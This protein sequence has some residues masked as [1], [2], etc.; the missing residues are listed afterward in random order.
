MQGS[1]LM[2]KVVVTGA[3]SFIGRHLVK[4]LSR[5][6]DL[7]LRL[8]VHSKPGEESDGICCY[9]GDLLF[10]ETLTEFFAGASVAINLAYL[11]SRSHDDNLAAACN[12]AD[13]CAQAGVTRVI[14]CSTAVVSGRTKTDV[15]T[16]ATPCLPANDYE[17]TKLEMEKVLLEKAKGRFELVIIRPTA[18]FGP[19]GKNLLKMAQELRFGNGAVNYFRSCLFGLRRLNLVSINTIVGAVEFLMD[20][21]AGVDGEV[22]IVSD[23]ESYNNNYGYV[24][25]RMRDFF[26]LKP[27]ILPVV[28]LPNSMLTAALQLAGRSNVNPTR[29]Y[30]CDKLLDLG[31]RKNS[32]FESCL[33]LYLEWYA[34]AAAGED[35]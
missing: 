33:D 31:Y 32:T 22:F 5:R 2:T 34:N 8:L 35:L 15:V 24:E 19:N 26:R 1:K 18:V 27:Y 12:M 6:R 14:H 16:E 29:T 28:P 11:W 17:L 9:R 13:A 21:V 4:E 23:D 3:H 20:A 10:P 25:R 7:E 30:S